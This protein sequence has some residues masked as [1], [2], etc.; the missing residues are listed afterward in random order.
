MQWWYK[1]LRAD[2]EGIDMGPY[3]SAEEAN[4]ASAEHAKF[5]AATT[6]AFETDDQY[7]PYQGENE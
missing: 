5:G 1:Y 3:S 7:R 4:K 6:Q 2:L